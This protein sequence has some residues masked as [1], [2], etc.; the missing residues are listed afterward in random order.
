[1]R[2]AMLAPHLNVRG[3]L[4]KHTPLLVDALRRQ[5]CDVELLPW[6]RHEEG[7]GFAAKVLRRPRDVLAARRAIVDGDFSV[8]VVKTAHDWLTL[9]RDIAL[10][11]ALPRDRVV[12]VQ[13]HGS[14]S[15]RLVAPGSRAF[16]WASAALVRQ[17]DGI[18]VLSRQEAAEWQ[19]FRPGSRVAVV[20]N[21]R[22]ASF[23]AGD[24]AES[25]ANGRKTVLFVA[26]LIANKGVLDLVRALPLLQETVPCRLVLAG[27]G[28]EAEHVRALA[29]DLGVADS[30]ELAGYVEGADL[31]RLYDIADVFALPTTHDEGFPTVILEAMAAGLPIVT[32]PTRGPVDHLVDGRHAVF[33]P[34]ADPRALAQGIAQLLTDDELRAAM[35]AANREKARE[36]DADPVAAEYLA[37]LTEIV[38]ASRKH[39]AHADAR[40]GA[41]DARART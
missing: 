13:F 10:V 7:E 28:P 14:Q 6:G 2:I 41:E 22:P 33:V 4:P 21:P 17:V 39:A 31:A 37:A 38:R 20:R 29:A 27:E 16:K 30:V 40:A 26:R 15:S 1:M 36:F 25:A 18:F 34:A 24:P 5:G 8:V 9:S 19:A 11:Q 23:A 32:T 3:P 35:G 12:V